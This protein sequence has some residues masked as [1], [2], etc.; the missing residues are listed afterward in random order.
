MNADY[1]RTVQ[2]LLAVA[3]AVFDV[4]ALAMTGGAACAPSTP[5][6]RRLRLGSTPLDSNP[7]RSRF[8]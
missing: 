5:N 4:T 2:L 6:W 7:S 1:V 3:S 8:K